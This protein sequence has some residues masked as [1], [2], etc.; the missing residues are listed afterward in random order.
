M[1]NSVYFFNIGNQL[2]FN[3]LA[4]GEY[5]L[6][7]QKQF[8]LNSH[9]LFNPNQP[10]VRFRETMLQFYSLFQGT[11]PIPAFPDHEQ[12]P[13]Q[14]IWVDN[15]ATLVANQPPNEPNLPVALQNISSTINP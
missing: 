10:L 13:A 14:Y 1:P 3:L 5:R 8:Q 6:S 2:Q 9:E 15:L 7:W 12:Y 4:Q 11:L